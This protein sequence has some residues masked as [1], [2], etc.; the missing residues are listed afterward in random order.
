MEYRRLWPAFNGPPKPTAGTKAPL[1]YWC[2]TR[3]SAKHGVIQDVEV[4]GAK[5]QFHAIGNAEREKGFAPTALSSCDDF[6]NGQ[7][8]QKTPCLRTARTYAILTAPLAGW[9]FKRATVRQPEIK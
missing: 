4:L 9:F 5:L 8:R 7:K 2:E 6:R 3:P 1:R